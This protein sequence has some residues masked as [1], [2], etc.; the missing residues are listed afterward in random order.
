MEQKLVYWMRELDKSALNIVGKKCA[1]LG[2]MSNMGLTVP[3][4][5]AISVVGYERFMKE[6]G[7]DQEIHEYLQQNYGSEILKK[8]SEAEAASN[9]VRKMIEDK[10][11]PED[12]EKEIIDAYHTLG[13]EMGMDNV[14]VSVRS[15]GAVSMPGQFETYLYVRGAGEVITHVIRCWGSTFTP[16]A[17]MFRAEKGLDLGIWPIGVAVIKMVNAK[18]AGIMFTLNPVTGDR[19]KI[20]IEANWGLGESVV[21]GRV[22]P[23]RFKINKITLEI[24]EKRLGRKEEEYIYDSDKRIVEFKEVPVERQKEFCLTDEEIGKLANFGKQAERLFG[25][26][27]QDI[28]W[29]IDKDLPSENNTLLLQARPETIW[30]SK[31]KKEVPRARSALDYI[32]STLVEG[33]KL[34]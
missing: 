15:S 29:A 4:G 30:A 22:E 13:K 6:T 12:M 1:N 32:A 20:T 10:T 21:S 14:E 19:S 34:K 3:P 5:F 25:G 17:I 11:M 2:E 31:Q 16:R 23:D 8:A 7:V 33:R 24:E 28:E 18:A 26:E 9:A 27:P